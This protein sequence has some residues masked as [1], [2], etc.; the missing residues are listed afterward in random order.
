MQVTEGENPT[1][2]LDIVMPMGTC[3]G[4]ARND[5]LDKQSGAKSEYRHSWGGVINT[6]AVLSSLTYSDDD[7]NATENKV[8]RNIGECSLSDDR[9]YTV[10][11][12]LEL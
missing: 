1:R 8:N 7:Y 9:P 5:I 11:P 10:R 6:A 3:D 2:K 4:M 12:A